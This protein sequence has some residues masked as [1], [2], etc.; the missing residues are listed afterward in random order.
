MNGK[1]NDA[2][3]RTVKDRVLDL[4]KTILGLSEA[5]AKLAINYNTLLG[6]LDED[7]IEEENFKQKVSITAESMA[8]LIR[9]IRDKMEFTEENLNEAVALNQVDRL[10]QQTQEMIECGV[11][12]ETDQIK[13]KDSYVVSKEFDE[14][15]KVIAKRN[16]FSLARLK[17]EFQAKFIGKRNGDEI[18]LKEG[19]VVKIIKIYDIVEPEK[20]K[21]PTQEDINK[22]H[23]EIVEQTQE[24]S[25]SPLSANEEVEK[26]NK[27]LKAGEEGVT[28]GEIEDKTKQEPQS[29]IEEISN[30]EEPPASS[31]V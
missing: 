19:N 18:K 21:T 10:I 26:L 1:S 6:K 15:G 14:E 27:A 22:P 25:K 13:G 17:K 4:E 23:A 5:Y 24:A 16:Q 9:C 3:R 7:K 31:D 29:N 8:G 20:T 12:K 30:V 28:Q 2:P 11:L